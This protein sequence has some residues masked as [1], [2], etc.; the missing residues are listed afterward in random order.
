LAVIRAEFASIHKT[1]AK[2]EAVEK[3]PLPNAPEADPVPL[4]FLQQLAIEGRDK[5]VVQAGNRLVDLIVKEVLGQIEKEGKGSS[6]TYHIHSDVYGAVGENNTVNF[7]KQEFKPVYEAIEASSRDASEKQILIDEV[8]IIKE[9]VAKG[10]EVNES[11]LSRRLHNLKKMA[12]DIAE[13]ALSTLANPAAGA[14]MIV[15]KIAKKIKGE[16]K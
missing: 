13:V 1:V 7:I 5:L 14:G 9:E 4:A 3:V 6:P 12:P 11:F 2:I 15:Q 10:D 8:D 16:T